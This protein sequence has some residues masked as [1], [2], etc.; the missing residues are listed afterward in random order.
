MISTT[1]TCYVTHGFLPILYNIVN[2]SYFQFFHLTADLR[3]LMLIY[4]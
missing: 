2:D 4:R 3:L 1:I